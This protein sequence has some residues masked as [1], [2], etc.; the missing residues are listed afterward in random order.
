MKSVAHI[1]QPLEA[2]SFSLIISK[3]NP[4]LKR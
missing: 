4:Y 1:S 3:L 2:W